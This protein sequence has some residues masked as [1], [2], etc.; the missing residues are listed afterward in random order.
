[1][2]EFGKDAKAAAP[3][4]LE[5]V[6]E[7]K[8]SAGPIVTVNSAPGFTVQTSTVGQMATNALREI[9]PEAAAQ[10]GMTSPW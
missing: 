10:A 3:A 8:R 7:A 6:R 4:L 9:D 1:L 2:R 5:L